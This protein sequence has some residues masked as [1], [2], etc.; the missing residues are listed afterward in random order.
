MHTLFLSAAVW[1]IVADH[2][3][4]AI[5][6]FRYADSSAARQV[7]IASGDTP[8][9]ELVPDG[10]GVALR[11]DAPFASQPAVPR[12]TI[13]REVQ[14]DLSVSSCFALEIKPA[15]AAGDRVSLYFR[16][17]KGWF[18]GGANLSGTCWQT[19]KFPKHAFSVEGQPS[20]WQ[21]IDGI[22]ISVWKTEAR[23]TS[24]L[25][26]RL[27]ASRSDTAIIVPDSAEGELRTARDAAEHLG[28]MLNELGVASDQ[29]T[30]SAVANGNLGDRRLAILPYNPTI[31]ATACAALAGFA[32]RGGKLFVCYVL[33]PPLAQVLGVRQGEY[34]RQK[35]PGD[36]ASI[37]FEDPAIQ[38]LPTSVRQA[39]WNI[40]AAMPDGQNARVI[41]RWFDAADQ[42]TGKSALVIS[43]R[44]AFFSHIVLT[45][46]WAGKKDL[47][48]AVL[49]H[50]QPSLWQELAKTAIARSEQIGHCR[51]SQQLADLV[52]GLPDAALRAQLQQADRQLA[53][54]RQLFDAGRG[55]EASRV[56]KQVRELR[57]AAY[58]RA[59]PSP[60]VEG[61]AFWEHSGT[62][63]YP[64]DWD[65][66]AKELAAAGFNMVIP[67]M[68]WAGRA[69]YASDVLPRSQA[70]EKYGD[71]I[72]QC[73]AAGKK[74]GVEVH[75][76]KVNFNLAGAPREFV[77]RLRKEGRTQVDVQG[78]PTDWLDPSH[79]ENFRLELDSLLEVVRK[80]DVDGIH[81]DY[82][83]YPDGQYSFSDFSRQQFEKDTGQQVA[84][85]PRDCYSGPLRDKYRTWRCAQITRLVEAVH[86]EAK[87]IRP[88]IKISAAVF[89]AYPSCRE[90]VAQ[91]WPVWVRNGYLDFLCPMD[92]SDSDDQF[93]ALVKSQQQLV[94]G[95]IP[96]YPGIGA[97][98]SRSALS[99]DR[100]VGQIKLARELGAQ[101]F[102]IFNLSESTA[103]DLL[104]GIAL[105]AGQ[106]PATVS[107]R[108]PRAAAGTP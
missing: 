1:F 106:T 24:Y 12:T 29:L 8:A 101:G 55:Y 91:D 67:N 72:A 20:G 25:L 61:R 14:L 27:A 105:G 2:P 48:A 75:V 74:H 103:R 31:D 76:W 93:A 6:E 5:D 4:G 3:Q 86:R 80:Y 41:G 11:V 94:G 104:P 52:S 100:V 28:R 37:R 7:W 50:L 78:R 70:F 66:T 99:V 38:G 49:G 98:A 88:T 45:D 60:A 64:G 107:H 53:E 87:Q 18:S 44:G 89:G 68:L 65:R 54:A 97:T 13:D 9:V 33:P 17:G 35:E 36:L 96:L 57:V 73:V 21:H 19:L 62:G 81:F 32:E 102:T 85:W 71:Q 46:D 43:D 56:A 39:S 16:S 10:D 30:E 23:D 42:P 26:R 77:E 84:N 59:Q 92:Y 83:R 15:A 108:Q 79:P 69:H 34:V 82:I 90:S 63:A 22:R 95:R 40:H 47:L 51:S 58:L